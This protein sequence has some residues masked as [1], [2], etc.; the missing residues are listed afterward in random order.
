MKKII[1][2]LILAFNCAFFAK[3]ENPFTPQPW[4]IQTETEFSASLVRM[5]PTSIHMLGRWDGTYHTNE[6]IFLD[7]ILHIITG[8]GYPASSA[9]L[10]MHGV[11]DG[12][13][14]NNR[15]IFLDSILHALSGSG[16]G[17]FLSASD[18]TTANNG[19]HNSGS[20]NIKLGGTLIENTTISTTGSYYLTVSGSNTGR[21]MYTENTGTGRALD[22]ISQSGDAFL[23]SSAGG[24]GINAT[25]TT[26]GAGWFTINPSSTNTQPQVMRFQRSTSGVAATSLGGTLDFYSEASTGN[27]RLSNQILWK[28]SNATEA[29]QTS[30]FEIWNTNAAVSQKNFSISGPGQIGFSNYGTGTFTG[31]ASYTLSVTASGNVIETP[32]QVSTIV[33][34]SAADI[35]TLNSVPIDLSATYPA[36]A[37]AYWRIVNCDIAYV[38]G[39]VTFTNTIQASTNGAA[40]TQYSYD[41]SLLFGGGDALFSL[42]DRRAVGVS[43][44]R[45]N[46]PLQIDAA[47]DSA[48]GDGS[49]TIY[50]TAELV[51]L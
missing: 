18:T 4:T 50:I 35:Q 43:V 1:L 49:A 26:G 2:I 51:T 29:A 21:T 7:S 41:L 22:A 40:Q 9:G 38:D 31:T 45:A 3:A 11:W 27:A 8:T 15:E 12:I 10:H 19:L 47:G 39:A 6:E 17:G 32:A 13:Y 25:S 16:G 36:T 20:H 48:T 37:G 30:I 5:F 24:W 34:L 14:H 23:A 28:W 42:T 44:Y 33:I 46:K